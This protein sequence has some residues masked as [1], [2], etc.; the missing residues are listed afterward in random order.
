MTCVNLLRLAHLLIH[1][2]LQMDAH[3][4]RTRIGSAGLV[5]GGICGE[6][7]CRAE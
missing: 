2:I 5:D 3:E 7:G 6:P 1:S 4:V